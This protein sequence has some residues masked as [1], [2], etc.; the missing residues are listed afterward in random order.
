MC[1]VGLISGYAFIRLLK[2]FI[3]V[4]IFSAFKISCLLKTRWEDKVV[5]TA[6]LRLSNISSLRLERGPGK[7]VSLKLGFCHLLT[8]SWCNQWGL[9]GLRTDGTSNME[10]N[11]PSVSGGECRGKLQPDKPVFK[12]D[13]H[14]YDPL[15]SKALLVSPKI[16][17][18]LP[19]KP[20]IP[21]KIV[22]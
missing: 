16:V 11:G 5:L 19:S 13:L 8:A 12:I 14:R 20:L 3:C 15:V 2:R 18:L 22:E 6:S 1:H 17:T 21:P 4:R 7:G 10:G 9:P